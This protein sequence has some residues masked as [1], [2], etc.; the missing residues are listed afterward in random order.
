MPDIL[1]PRETSAPTFINV[2]YHTAYAQHIQQLKCREWTN[3]SDM[4]TVIK[5]TDDSPRDVLTMLTDLLT[6]EAVAYPDTMSF[7][8]AILYTKETPESPAILRKVKGLSIAGS[9]ASSD[10]AEAVQLSLNGKDTEGKTVKLVLLDVPSGNVFSKLYTV[11]IAA[12]FLAI[13][14]EFKDPDNGWQSESNHQPDELITQTLTLNEKLRR[15][16]RLT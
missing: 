9:T 13:W 4:G 2:F 14:A 12:A 11:D 16:Y 10:W 5:W 3:G 7:D 6:L 1:P 15:G 8:L